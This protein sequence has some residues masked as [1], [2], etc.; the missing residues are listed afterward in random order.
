MV[1]QKDLIESIEKNFKYKKEI[2]VIDGKQFIVTV[3]KDKVLNILSFLK[4]I[5]FKQLALITAVDWIDEK[6][7]E[8][9]YVLFSYSHIQQVLVKTFVERDNPQVE[10]VKNLWDVASMY[11]RDVHEFFGIDFVGNDDL[12]PLILHN[13]K[14][15]PPLRKD[16]D[17]L[18]YSNKMFGKFK[19][20]EEL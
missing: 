14:D 5:D 6:K 2:K 1:E 19:K 11:E 3:E 20:D 8:I 15:L 18:K 10:T 7:F 16:F 12:R 9:V 17:S 13:W 4:L